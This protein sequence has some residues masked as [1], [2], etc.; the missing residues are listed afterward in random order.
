ML[1]RSA[2][3]GTGTENL[4]VPSAVQ[5]IDVINLRELDARAQA[6]IPKGNYDYIA[7]AA[8]DE[9]TMAENEAAFKR[10]TITPR[11]LT[12]NGKPDL[13]ATL[14]GQKLSMPVMM[15]AIGGHGIAHV[16]AEVG[17]T[18]GAAAAGVMMTVPTLSNQTM[19]EIAAASTG[20]KC[21]QVY[22][23]AEIGRAH[24]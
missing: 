5:K 3:K 10:F 19:E 24:V 8:G 11:F 23:P 14:M 13:S 2:Q 20:P 9:W 16:S 4:P 21:F 22:F 18:K 6:I 7:G 17:T 12:G 15:S 1:F